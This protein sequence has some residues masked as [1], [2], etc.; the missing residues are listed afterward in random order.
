[1][2]ARARLK[3]R[4]EA[5]F[6]FWPM[7]G[8]WLCRHLWDH[9][10][11]GRD[12]KFLAEEAYPLMKGAALFYLDWLREDGSGHLVT[13]IAT[14][15]EN[16][17]ETLD[18]QRA[19]VSMGYTLD[20][21]IIR[22]L[23]SST[24]KAAEILDVDPEVRRE[25]TARKRRLLPPGMGRYGQLREWSKDWDRPED[26]HRHLSHLYAAYPGEE[27]TPWGTPELARAAVR[28]LEMRGPGNV[29]WSRAWMVNLWAR[30]GY[31]ERA[32]ER[33][34]QMLVDGTSPNL[35][36]Q[37]Y[38]GRPLP[39]EIDANLGGPSGIAEMLLQ[40]HAGAIRLLPALPKAWPCGSVRGFRARGGLE[41]D[42]RWEGGKLA[43]ATVRS[44]AGNRCRIR[45]AAALQLADPPRREAAR[46][47]SPSILEFDTDPGGTYVLRP[48]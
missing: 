7:A 3:S 29:G 30:L 33:L 18:G 17:F 15:P 43:G 46:S 27:I 1:M 16:R 12:R 47:D 13:P 42:M 8:G 37:C 20:M 31:P 25:L 22:E 24:V 36:E 19:S 35:F 32:Y 40:S 45:A 9:Y 28:S 34:A 26:H 44:R 39:F 5:R 38:A 2:R 4:A 41:V 14:S 48:R 21:S 23:F 6:S 11:F 10:E